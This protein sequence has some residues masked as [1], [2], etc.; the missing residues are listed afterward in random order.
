[1]TL[2]GNTC[3]LANFEFRPAGH[4]Q[5]ACH[6]LVFMVLASPVI[7]CK[8]PNRLKEKEFCSPISTLELGSSSNPQLPLRRLS[9]R[10]AAATGRR[11]CQGPVAPSPSLWARIWSTACF[12]STA[13]STKTSFNPKWWKCSKKQKKEAEMCQKNI[14]TNLREREPPMAKAWDKLYNTINSRVLDYNPEKE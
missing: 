6:A 2:E 13:W 7:Q 4:K 10:Q 8:F 14:G 1:M 12:Q 3:T 5:S 11:D 9:G